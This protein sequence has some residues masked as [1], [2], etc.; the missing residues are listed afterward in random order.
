MTATATIVLLETDVAAR[1]NNAQADLYRLLKT[2]ADAKD[3]QKLIATLDVDYLTYDKAGHYT[4]PQTGNRQR[5]MIVHFDRDE[6]DR[7]MRKAAGFGE[8]A[9]KASELY[10]KMQTEPSLGLFV[11]ARHFISGTY[12]TIWHLTDETDGLCNLLNF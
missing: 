4:H 6:R 5:G 7:S 9:A 10:F 1:A 8:V 2:Y 11:E 12:T 3:M